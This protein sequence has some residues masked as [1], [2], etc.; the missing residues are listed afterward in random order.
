M[1]ASD[2]DELTL[3]NAPTIARWVCETCGSAEVTDGRTAGHPRC[4]KHERT[5]EEWR[6]E[7][8]LVGQ[9]GR[10]EAHAEVFAALRQEA[11]VLMDEAFRARALG[12]ESAGKIK[13][14]TAKYLLSVVASL[15]TK[16]RAQ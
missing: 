10:F 7:G 16:L 4:K 15:P 14:G 6:A 9:S 3:G 2:Y 1:K 8:N 12:Q 11:G 5:P 13:E